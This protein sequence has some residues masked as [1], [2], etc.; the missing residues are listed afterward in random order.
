MIHIAHLVTFAAATH[1]R[2]EPAAHREPG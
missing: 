2:K 1:V